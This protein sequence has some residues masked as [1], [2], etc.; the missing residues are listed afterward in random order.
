VTRASGGGLAGGLTGL[1]GNQA[2]GARTADGQI[3]RWRADFPYHWD[4]D[5]LVSRRQLLHLAVYASG[6]LFLSTAAIALLGA[7]RRPRA[8]APKQIARV[9]DVPE[10]RFVYFNYPA[11]GDQAVL[12]HLKGGQLVAYSQ[13]CTHL[14]CAVIYQPE[15]ERLFCPC[16][17]GVFSPLNGAPTAGPPLRPLPQIQLRREG[18]LLYAVGVVP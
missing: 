14:S 9:S 17:E 2:G 7:L 5:D 10:G 8:A 16:H 6:A 4:T 1:R 11:E 12:L 3:K 13:K 18:D 15:R